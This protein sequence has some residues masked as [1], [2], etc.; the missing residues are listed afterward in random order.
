MSK[1]LYV[2][3]PHVRVSNL[4]ESEKLMQFVLSS[5]EESKVDR[6]V[7]LGDLTHNHSVLRV[8]VL[9]FWQ[10]WLAELG[11]KFDT[12]VLVGN[13]DQ[14]GDYNSKSNSLSIYKLLNLSKLTI[15]DEPTQL[16]VFAYVPYIH[17]EAEFVAAA[18]ALANAGAK[19]LI[20]HQTFQGAK[21]ESGIFAPDGFDQETLNY[22]WI[23][24]GHLH[25]RSSF[26][27]VTYPGTATWQSNSD[28]NSEKGLWLVDFD[29]NAQIVKQEYLDT[30]KVV[31]PIYSITWR[32][33]EAQP[34]IPQGRVTVELIGTS[35][36]I[37]QQK[38]IFKGKTAFKSKITDKAQARQRKGS[39]SMA[40]FLKDFKS[41]IDQ[42]S[43]LEMMKEFEIV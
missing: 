30:S 10:K 26:G 22:N 12:V 18:N 8:E 23:D 25:S 36:W 34:Q 27:K 28:A 2:G 16:G 3:D 24:S 42:E 9:E 37:N 1:H 32:E 29:Q 20:C 19:R 33:G 38:P 31:E 11:S 4:A 43:L 14:T 21:Y 5:A 7:L 41:P 6:I 13:H 17:V 35:A 15:V 40:E 39:Q